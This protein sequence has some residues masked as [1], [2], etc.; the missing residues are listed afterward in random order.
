[1]DSEFLRNN[2]LPNPAAYSG[3][4]T[5][6][7]FL[8]VF[9]AIEGYGRFWQGVALVTSMTGDLFESATRLIVLAR[10]SKKSHK[11]VSVF[12][13][14]VIRLFSLLNATILAS[15]EGNDYDTNENSSRLDGA[16]DFDGLDDA[17][18]KT[19]LDSDTKAET[20]YQMIHQLMT[21]ELAT[22][23]LSKGNCESTEII[24]VGIFTNLATAIVKYHEARKLTVISFPLPFIAI[25]RMMMFILWWLT[26]AV[27]TLWTSSVL[28]AASVTFSVMFVQV[29]LQSI[30][31]EL[32]NPFN[33]DVDSE[34][35]DLGALQARFNRTLMKSIDESNKTKP[36]LENTSNVRRLTSKTSHDDKISMTYGIKNMLVRQQTLTS[37]MTEAT[38]KSKTSTASSPEECVVNACEDRPP[39]ADASFQIPGQPIT[40]ARELPRSGGQPAEKMCH[41]SNDRLY[42]STRFDEARLDGRAPAELEDQHDWQGIA[43]A[44]RP[45]TGQSWQ[46]AKKG[47]HV[48]VKVRRVTP[49]AEKIMQVSDEI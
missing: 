45:S 14:V 29:S 17:T 44:P 18:K 48:P 21:D 10:S 37:Q 6:T 27:A 39:S 1:M 38:L 35:L 26:P 20:V 4:F 22:G 46:P 49:E 40:P 8:C 3:V 5:L 30:A 13:A 7:S 2:L 12:K 9:R 32:D 31:N 34:V 36:T 24:T 33:S 11:D 15:L 42:S 47:D 16:L 19:Y 43:E 28:G 41:A 23:L 25:L